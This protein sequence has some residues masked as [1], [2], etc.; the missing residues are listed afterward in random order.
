MGLGGSGSGQGAGAQAVSLIVE[1]GERHVRKL[2]EVQRSAERV[3]QVLRVDQIVV[4][5]PRRERFALL[6]DG[7][8][9][10]AVLLLPSAEEDGLLV[11]GEAEGSEQHG[12]VE[13]DRF[14]GGGSGVWRVAN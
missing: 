5:L 12:G 14:V 13:H 3:R 2:V 11:R 4:H 1:F 6:G 10:F 9:T 8:I 7:R